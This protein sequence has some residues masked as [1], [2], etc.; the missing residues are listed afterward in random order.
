MEEPIKLR[1]AETPH[2]A[3]V[4]DSPWDDPISNHVRRIKGLSATAKVVWEFLYV[5]VCHR[6]LEDHVTIT[7]AEIARDQNID[8]ANARTALKRLDAFG[9][10]ASRQHDKSTGFI[11]LKLQNPLEVATGRLTRR[12]DEQAEL[13]LGSC[14]IAPAQGMDGSPRRPPEGME[15]PSAAPPPDPLP[16]AALGARSSPPRPPPNAVEPST[17]SSMDPS[18]EALAQPLKTSQEDDYSSNLSNLSLRKPLSAAPTGSVRRVVTPREAGGSIDGTTAGGNAA[19]TNDGL[20]R[21]GDLLA[22]FA[23][24][25][26]PSPARRIEEI[27]ELIGLMKRDVGLYVRS[28]RMLRQIA[29]LVADRVFPAAQL[30]D[31]LSSFRKAL[32]KGTIFTEPGWYFLK[33]VQ[34]LVNDRAKFHVA[35]RGGKHNRRPR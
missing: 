3:G 33:T 15:R 17:N 34:R 26:M 30:Q 28:E 25:M 9:L 8:P 23:D 27:Q 22:G 31:C 12:G 7:A 35:D 21:A 24:R 6:V 19:T 1:V 32:A 18:T 5:R 29:E 14:S 20:K 13:Q 10:I 4:E 16:S 2:I 11:T